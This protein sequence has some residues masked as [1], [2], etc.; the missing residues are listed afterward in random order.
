[1]IEYRKRYSVL[2]NDYKKIIN[3]I[4]KL[5]KEEH[6]IQLHIHPHWEDS[7]FGMEIDGL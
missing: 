6:D 7:Y 1:L 2:E 3:Q 4:T 5:N